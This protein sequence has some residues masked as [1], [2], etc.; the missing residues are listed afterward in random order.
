MFWKNLNHLSTRSGFQ[1][2]RLI[3]YDIIRFLPWLWKQW[4]NHSPWWILHSQG[5]FY[6]EDKPL[7]QIVLCS[8]NLPQ[9]SSSSLEG[10]LASMS[11]WIC[12]KYKFTSHYYI[13]ILKIIIYLWILYGKSIKKKNSYWY[14]YTHKTII[15][16]IVFQSFIFRHHPTI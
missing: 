7:T 6:G 14:I 9:T 11:H 12:K 4:V 2:Y 13:F 5:W 1:T 10:F 3:D 8:R 15:I 16:Y